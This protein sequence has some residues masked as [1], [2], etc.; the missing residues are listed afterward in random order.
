MN[1]VVEDVRKIRA[2]FIRGALTQLLDKLA[3]GD[4]EDI[5]DTARMLA[6]Y[7]DWFKYDFAPEVREQLTRQ[8]ETLIEA[9]EHISCECEAQRSDTLAPVA[10]RGGKL[11]LVPRSPS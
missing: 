4:F 2:D 5:A 6:N 9:A 3:S 8:L 7:F 11:H 10:M 1:A